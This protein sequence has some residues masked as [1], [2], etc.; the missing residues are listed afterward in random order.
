MVYDGSDYQRL[1][2][3]WDHLSP[4]VRASVPT[5]LAVL[6]LLAVAWWTLG[7]PSARRIEPRLARAAALA[8]AIRYF[9]IDNQQRMP[10]AFT[11]LAPYLKADAS[12]PA[13]VQAVQPDLR[14][15]KSGEFRPDPLVLEFLRRS[16]ELMVLNAGL[17]RVNIIVD[18]TAVLVRERK[19]D[20]KGRRVEGLASGA[21]VTTLRVEG[22]GIYE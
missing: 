20:L 15:V 19:A 13:G 8:G 6:A 14:R 2:R 3:R 10:D 4:L 12:A 16:D 7:P 9:S 1:R 17:S 11:D 18:G 21:A 22:L 5:L